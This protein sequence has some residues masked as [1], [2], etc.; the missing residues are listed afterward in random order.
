MHFDP[1]DILGDPADSVSGNRLRACADALENAHLDIVS[2]A[3]TAGWTEDEVARGFLWRAL[4]HMQV[5]AGVAFE[6]KD[7]EETLKSLIGG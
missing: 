1:A 2:D 7:V 5:L 4:F 3:V 6:L